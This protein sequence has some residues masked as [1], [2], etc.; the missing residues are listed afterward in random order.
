VKRKTTIAS[1]CEDQAIT[2]QSKSEGPLYERFRRAPKD[3]DV[4]IPVIIQQQSKEFILNN[5]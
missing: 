5:Q 3:D 4:R 2:L 1:G